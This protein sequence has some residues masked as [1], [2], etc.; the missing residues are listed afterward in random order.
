MKSK[1]Q[2]MTVAEKIKYLRNL[3]GMTQKE[4]AE[5][6]GIEPSII[7]KYEIG[8]RN[9]K[10]EQVQLI[11]DALGVNPYVFY[12][13]TLYSVGDAM[14]LIMSLNDQTCLNIAGEK[15]AEGNYIPTSINISFSDNNLNEIL[16]QYKTFQEKVPKKLSTDYDAEKPDDE[17]Q[18]LLDRTKLKKHK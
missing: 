12:D 16:A 13:N 2:N 14:A 18:F 10:Y 1:I 17:I 5:A 7:R 6:S 3:K 9:P 15:D 8:G 11:A 4:L